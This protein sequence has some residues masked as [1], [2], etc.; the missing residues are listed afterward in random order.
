VL[1]A[2]RADSALKPLPLNCAF[3]SSSLR[4]W[5]KKITLRSLSVSIFSAYFA[6][7]HDTS[8][9]IQQL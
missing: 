9:L 5:S 1:H 2:K 4:Q 3:G 7:M 6:V 8:D